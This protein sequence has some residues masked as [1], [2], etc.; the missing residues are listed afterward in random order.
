MNIRFLLTKLLVPGLPAYSQLIPFQCCLKFDWICFRRSRADI[1]LGFFY[2]AEGVFPANPP[3]TVEEGALI[4]LPGFLDVVSGLL[5]AYLL[6]VLPA[7][8]SC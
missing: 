1:S 8:L 7:S 6:S 2:G 3:W 5:E 4:K